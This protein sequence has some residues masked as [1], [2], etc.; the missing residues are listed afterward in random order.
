VLG[1]PSA[2]LPDDA[3]FREG[4]AA[5][6]AQHLA[7]PGPARERVLGAARALWLLRGRS[8]PE[9]GAEQAPPDSWDLARVLRRLERNL[10]QA[11]LVLRRARYLS[12]LADA[13]V[14]YRELEMAHARA[15]IVRG[16]ALAERQTLP[17]ELALTGVVARRARERDAG[18]TL[19]IAAYDR[20]RVLATELKRVRDEGGEVLVRLGAHSF[21][22]ERFDALT[23]AV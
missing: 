6:N 19:D 23:R 7:Q 3:L 10:V 1:V 13:D 11:A 14:A 22:A 12:L 9:S 16:G 4:F 20:L 2:F 17:A 21:A 5:F 8:E 15:L 18:A